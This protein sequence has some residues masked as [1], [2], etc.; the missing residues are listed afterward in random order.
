FGFVR[1]FFNSKLLFSTEV[2]YKLFHNQIDYKDHAN[3]LF[4]PLIEGELRFGEAQS[5][6]AEFML[7]KPEGKF[8]GWLG[9]TYSKAIKQIDGINNNESFPAY[10]DRP[11]DICV[12]V[13]YNNTR[14]WAISAN[15]IFL[16]GGAI[17]TP[18]GFFYYNGY[19]VPIYGAKNNSRLPNYHRLDLSITY[20]INKPSRKYQHSL[21]F[22]LYNAYGRK[23]PI[24]AN[25][26]KVVD[27][28]G[29]FIV[30]SDLNG[31]Y[32]IVPTTI[33]VAGAIP[34][35]TYNFKF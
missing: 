1:D 24:S 11:H 27:D 35:L 20:N 18:T 7:R 13:S 19:S 4:N 25:F 2:F 17:T 6:G 21:A 12:N 26:N 34:S 10:Y 5:Y 22:S 8:T 15:W 3:M 16:S 33:S 32:D 31:Q 23:N 14:H 30:P 29:N 28:N 9:Y